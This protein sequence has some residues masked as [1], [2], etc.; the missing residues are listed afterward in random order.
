MVCVSLLPTRDWGSIQVSSGIAP[1]L[2]SP[3]SDWGFGLA[4]WEGWLDT[5]TGTW[6]YPMGGGAG[7]GHVAL[8]W[9]VN[10]APP[11][12]HWWIALTGDNHGGHYVVY[13]NPKGDGRVRTLA[14]PGMFICAT[15]SISSN[16]N[17]FFSC[18]WCKFDDDVVSLVSNEILF[19]KTTYT[20]LPISRLPPSPDHFSP[21]CPSFSSDPYLSW[22]FRQ[23]NKKQSTTIL[24]AMRYVC[25]PFRFCSQS[26]ALCEDRA[27]PA[28]L[29]PVPQSPISLIVDC[30]FPQFVSDCETDSLPKCPNCN[31]ENQTNGRSSRLKLVRVAR[32]DVEKKNS[33]N[34]GLAWSSFGKPGPDVVPVGRPNAECP[35]TKRPCGQL[36]TEWQ[37][38]PPRGNLPR[39]SAAWELGRAQK[40]VRV[41]RGEEEKEGFLPLLPPPPSH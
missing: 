6:A 21:P 40:F 8:L 31:V 14:S 41:G 32:S 34:P 24:V 33:T 18:Q 30:V 26:A 3:G 9:E 23:P 19:I 28:R 37:N 35:I 15:Q 1:S 11:D 7:V 38:S 5:Y 16:A 4:P 39:L 25:L 10:S 17:L 27:A 29:A 20:N 36:W 13:I 22:S 12:L 2:P